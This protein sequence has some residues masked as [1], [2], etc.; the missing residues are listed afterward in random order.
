M[1]LNGSP[2]MR[3]PTADW[4]GTLAG[5]LFDWGAKACV[6]LYQSA[7]I[8]EMYREVGWWGRGGCAEEWVPLSDFRLLALGLPP[9]SF[10]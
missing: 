3:A 4:Q 10:V 9:C 1:R 5:N 2:A 7:T 6:D 8:L